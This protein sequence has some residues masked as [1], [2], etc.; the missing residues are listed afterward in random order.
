MR[1]FEVG[2]LGLLGA[3]LLSYSQAMACNEEAAVA[4]GARAMSSAPYV[5][6][7]AITSADL[8]YSFTRIGRLRIDTSLNE[9]PT[10]ACTVDLYSRVQ[11]GPDRISNVRSI[12]TATT[13]KARKRFK[14]AN[15]PAILPSQGADP[16]VNFMVR[17]TCG[18]TIIDAGPLARYGNCGSDR[19]SP[20]TY[21]AWLN[22]VRRRLAE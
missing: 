10:E 8:R 16:I 5:T 11:I 22:E 19:R 2:F 1:K 17:W 7:G 20:V 14:V 18:D 9:A 6:A 12:A 4:E 15:L 21:N 3:A 13:T